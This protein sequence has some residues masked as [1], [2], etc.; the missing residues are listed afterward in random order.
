[1]NP[2]KFSPVRALLAAAASMAPSLCALLLGAASLSRPLLGA[3]GPADPA[4][5]SRLS[6]DDWPA[7]RGLTGDGKA[8]GTAP[9]RWS[10]PKAGETTGAA[11]GE[12]VVWVAD[13]PGRGHASPIVVGGR[14]FVATADESAATQSVLAYDRSSG[15]L[16]FATVVH[17]GG[18]EHRHEKNSQ[19]SATPASDGE[20]VFAVFLNGAA[21]WI[22]TLGLDGKTLWQKSAGAF[23]TMHGY[24]SSPVIWKNLVI[25]T[26]DS[27]AGSFIAA[28][29][30]VSGE[31][32]W[33][34][35]RRPVHSFATPA[36]G[37]LSG[38][39]QLVINAAETV[40]SYDPDS[41]KELWHCEGPTQIMACT[42]ALGPDRVLASGGFPDKEILC[43]RGDGAGD[44]TASHIAWRTTK[45]VTYVPSPI[46]H[47]GRFYV[48]S[49]GGVVTC[50][51]ASTGNEAWKGRLEGAFSS[52]PILA[53]GRFYVTNE[54]GVTHVFRGADKLELLA[55]N[56]LEDGGFATPAF[57]GG[58][59]YVRTLHRLYCIGEPRPAPPASS[60]GG[61]AGAAVDP[62]APAE[63]ARI[64]ATAYAVPKET[65]NE[66][67]GYFSIVEGKDGKV[68]VGTAKYRENAYLVEF[69]PSSKKMRVV[70]DAM[71]E[72]RREFPDRPDG[73]AKGFAAQSKFH[74]RNNV[75]ASGK[76]YVATKQGYPG[77]GEKREDYPGGY[78]MVYD[79]ATGKTRVYDIPV[80]HHGIISITPDESRGVAYVSTCSD[81]RPI[82]SAHFLVLDLATGKYRDL[83]DCRH[84]Y[85]F[86]VV[87]A[88]N[89]AYHPILGGDVARYD[90][91]ADRLERLRTTMDGQPLLP[92]SLFAAPE[93]HPI[94]WDITPQRTVLYAVAM[95]GNQ[96]YT[97][98]LAAEGD[99]LPGKSVGPLLRGSDG[100]DCRAMCVGPT[101]RVWAAVTGKHPGSN[102]SVLRLVSYAPG[103]GSPRDHGAITVTNPQYTELRDSESKPLPYHHGMRFLPDGRLEPLYPMGI[104]EARDGTVYVTVICPLTLL[105]IRP[106]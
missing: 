88:R 77:E 87:D 5:P 70:V 14:V 96:L 7:W 83:M 36:L 56:A 28:Y 100:T 16:L 63:I 33:E 45:G 11:T 47:D 95:S 84:M 105:A 67:S 32:A 35:A 90:P 9:M 80:R 39:P 48:V 64:A 21:V 42:L 23:K 106:E 75:G 103:D 98:D 101:S 76:I 54:A 2:R 4:R 52:S 41:G 94:N 19:A 72:I 104:C 29:D 15:A 97:Y 51:D 22:T 31:R 38:R 3:P 46:Y 6:A 102:D 20:R 37:S 62:A 79:P 59:V 43:L 82:D 93:G 60:S 10:M 49:D 91:A 61:S 25:V 44:V 34:T 69:D 53:D 92:G 18:L 55:S 8:V 68:Y 13:V 89:R 12:N 50:F 66:G 71:A 73:R 58:R 86:I 40:T 24:S 27:S 57:C 74:T 17:Q 81:E 78:P 1:M 85:A 99:T 26:A 30:R 65:T